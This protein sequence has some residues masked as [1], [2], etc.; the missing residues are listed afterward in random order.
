MEFLIKQGICISITIYQVLKWNIPNFEG[1]K[2]RTIRKILTD[3]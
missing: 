3:P 1:N 2:S